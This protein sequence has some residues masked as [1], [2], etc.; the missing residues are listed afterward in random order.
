MSIFIAYF[1]SK[2]IVATEHTVFN[3]DLQHQQK[4]SVLEC[5]TTSYNNLLAVFDESTA[6]IDNRNTIIREARHTAR[7]L[8]DLGSEASFISCELRTKLSLPTKGIKTEMAGLSKTISSLVDLLVQIDVN[9]LLIKNLIRQLPY[10]LFDSL[11]SF[12]LHGLPSTDYL[13]DKIPQG[14]LLLGCDMYPHTILEGIRT[15]SQ[16]SLLAQNTIFIWIITGKVDNYR[17]SVSSFFHSILG[18]RRDS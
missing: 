14:D 9:V 17:T 4:E 15:D 18:T 10:V 8:I 2:T 13:L 6:L 1:R 3:L 12:Q 11:K 5:F 7:A 16:S